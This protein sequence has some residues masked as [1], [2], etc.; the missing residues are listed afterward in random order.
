MVSD[1]R[2][3]WLSELIEDVE[4][5]KVDTIVARSGITGRAMPEPVAAWLDIHN[6]YWR[7]LQEQGL[8]DERD[9]PKEAAKFSGGKWLL[10]DSEARELLVARAQQG[11]EVLGGKPADL[12]VLRRIRSTCRELEPIVATLEASM[13]ESSNKATPPLGL[14]RKERAA[15]SKAW[16]LGTDAVVMQTIVMLD[17]DIITR[18]AEQYTDDAHVIVRQI[19]QQAVE[20]S[21]DTWERL[22]NGVVSI[23]EGLL[24]RRE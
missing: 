7:A 14:S 4:Q 19:H 3:T 5:R 2:K 6:A 10:P 15:L 12:C 20:T 8:I 9:A 21:I 24:K 11:L 23:F 1:E 18:I 17:G 13:S 22:V 16:E